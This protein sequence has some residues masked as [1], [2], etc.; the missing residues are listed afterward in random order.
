ML[1]EGPERT[2]L[3]R[4]SRAG[5]EELLRAERRLAGALRLA[6]L[7]ARESEGRLRLNLDTADLSGLLRRAVDEVQLQ[8]RDDEP[9]PWAVFIDLRDS[10]R[11][12]GEVV[13]D[14]YYLE[15]VFANVLS[16]AVKYSLPR[17]RGP[18]SRDSVAI[19]VFG[20]QQEEFVGVRVRNWGWWV[21]EHMADAIFKPWVRGYA[22]GEDAA[23]SGMGL[24]LHLARRLLAAHDGDIT[25]TSK[26]TEDM[27]VPRL[28]REQR[29]L[30]PRARERP[31][32]V[33]IY[34]TEFAIRVPRHLKTGVRTHVWTSDTAEGN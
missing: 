2:E 29:E 12:L 28:T 13:C 22:E 23:L 1:P 15:R 16:N 25:F 27:F 8:I 34:E 30:D 3:E 17:R 4:R 5:R 26:R 20:E 9:L 10:A 19:R 33:A 18:G 6:K 24:G 14:D 21:P 7:V 11:D 32:P 31:T